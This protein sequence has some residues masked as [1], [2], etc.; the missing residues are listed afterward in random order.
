MDAYEQARSSPRIP[1]RFQSV[2]APPRSSIFSL[3][4]AALGQSG[5]HSFNSCQGPIYQPYTLLCL[6]L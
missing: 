1:A 2:S 4:L 5:Y 3:A 6:L